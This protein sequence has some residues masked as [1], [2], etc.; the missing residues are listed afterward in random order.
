MNHVGVGFKFQRVFA[1][2]LL[3]LSGMIRSK[4]RKT[5]GEQN[6]ENIFFLNDYAVLI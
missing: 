1:F 3:V 2:V 6:E 5:G 4:G